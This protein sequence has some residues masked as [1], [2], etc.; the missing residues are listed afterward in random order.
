[1]PTAFLCAC[2]LQVS[3]ILTGRVRFGFINT[4]TKKGGLSVYK[5]DA[6]RDHTTRKVGLGVRVNARNPCK[7]S[8][9]RGNAGAWWG[10]TT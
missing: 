2:A 7:A 4:N 1:M 10:D 5:Y 9:K 3:R 8:G 6:S